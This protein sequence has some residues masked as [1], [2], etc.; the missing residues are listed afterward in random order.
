L[1]TKEFIEELRTRL[2]RGRDADFRPEGPTPD[3]IAVFSSH[4]P[5][6]NERAWIST[7]ENP[8]RY[9]MKDTPAGAALLAQRLDPPDYEPLALLAESRTAMA[10]KGQVEVHGMRGG[11]NGDFQNYVVDS[12]MRNDAI[13]HFNGVPR[14]L[15]E[16]GT[17]EQQAKNLWAS[18]LIRDHRAGRIPSMEN[19][20]D[21]YAGGSGPRDHAFNPPDPHPGTPPEILK[22]ARRF[23]AV[24]DAREKAAER[25][26]EKERQRRDR[27]DR[28]R[29][30]R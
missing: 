1:T 19:P 11:M 9:R 29:D 8:A 28:G 21:Y 16:K 23:E 26:Q 7:M 6:D 24:M 17:L 13:T 2:T 25:I 12:L 20:G 27:D 10:A 4:H 14:D 15:V 30:G 18:E 22:I 5:R 3:R